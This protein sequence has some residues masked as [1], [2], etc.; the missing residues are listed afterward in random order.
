MNWRSR[1][2]DQRCPFRVTVIALSSREL[3]TAIAASFWTCLPPCTR[4]PRLAPPL[5]QRASNARSFLTW[6]QRDGVEFYASWLAMQECYHVL[7]FAE[8]KK[9]GG[10][11]WKQFRTANRPQFLLYLNRG[12]AAVRTFHDLMNTLGIHM[13]QFGMP[14]FAFVAGREVTMCLHA[15]YLLAKFELDVADAFH[16]VIARKCKFDVA[17]SSDSDWRLLPYPTLVGA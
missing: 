1:R 4:P 11:R 3:P 5:V 10:A 12:R 16:F 15:R 17:V 2:R 6:A 7:L 8:L 9:H 13:I 14:P